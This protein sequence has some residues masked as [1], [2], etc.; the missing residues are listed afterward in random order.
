MFLFFSEGIWP[1]PITN[2]SY[3]ESLL[4]KTAKQ[5]FEDYLVTYNLGEKYYGVG[6]SKTSVTPH[7]SSLC[8]CSTHQNGG[9]NMSDL[10]VCV[11][12]NEKTN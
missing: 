8:L 9:Y 4:E 10:T 3:P 12:V 5:G 1:A 7:E 6:E 11:S 2:K